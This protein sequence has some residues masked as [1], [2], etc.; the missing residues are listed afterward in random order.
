[1][2]EKFEHKPL[3]NSGSI[4]KRGGNKRKDQKELEELFNDLMK[5]LSHG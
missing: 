1:M 2:E 3:E 4:I 5:G